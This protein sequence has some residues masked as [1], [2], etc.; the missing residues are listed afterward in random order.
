MR[1]RVRGRKLGRPTDQ[2]MALLKNLVTSLFRHEKVETTVA[3]AKE[4]SRLAERMITLAKRGD[5]AA[6]RQVHKLI[7]DQ[8]V[9]HHLFTEIAPRYE[10]R[11]GGYTRVTRAG[12]RRG[13]AAALAVLELSD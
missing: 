5:I 11:E 4:A 1:H 2:R 8:A 3:K 10:E 9:V 6:R 13:D 7:R 12:V